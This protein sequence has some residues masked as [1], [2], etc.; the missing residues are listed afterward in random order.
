M[1]ESSEFVD[2]A[3]PELLAL[4]VELFVRGEDHR[5]RLMRP[6]QIRARSRGEVEKPETINARTRKPERGGLHCARIFGPTEDLR[7]L[8]GKYQGEGHR[9]TTCEK[10]G[11]EVLPS[12]VRRERMAHVEL[13]A[14]V[15][16]PLF[17]PAIA[18][19][20]GL[21]LEQLG[22]LGEGAARF[23]GV[24]RIDRDAEVDTLG[25]RAV[26]DALASVDMQRMFADDALAPLAEYLTPTDLTLA[27]LPVLPAGLRP[28]EVGNDGRVT[29][30]DLN[31]HY[32][33]IVNRNNRLRRLVELEAPA[34]ILHN[35]YRFLQG[36]VDALV[37]NELLPEPLKIRG[38]ALRSLG[39][40][41]RARLDALGLPSIPALL[42][43]GADGLPRP[44]SAPL[45]DDED[46]YDF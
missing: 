15:V 43:R 44:A 39:A 32:R 38:R 28:V 4:G 14:P 18:R 42:G 36:A 9:G 19:L 20:L 3:A 7:C 16:H 11:V 33:R 21:D 22:A 45:L 46:E 27:V 37:H 13:V 17:A 29:S 34:I 35:E 24:G 8:C 40:A 26:H 5:A 25:G 31:D 12:A 6:A 30:S 2:A 41:A 10:C 1:D 23:L